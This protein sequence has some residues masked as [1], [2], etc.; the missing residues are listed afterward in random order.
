MPGQTPESALRSEMAAFWPV[1]YPKFGRVPTRIPNEQRAIRDVLAGA[2]NLSAD[3]KALKL[4]DKAGQ[5][6]LNSPLLGDT[7]IYLATEQNTGRRVLGKNLLDIFGA[8]PY[9]WDPNAVRVGVAALV[10]AGAVR[11]L[12]NKKPYTNPVDRELVDALRVSR[13]FNKVELVLEEIIPDDMILTETRTFLIH[14]AK[15][16]NIDETPAALSEAAGA[17][18]EAIL[19]KADIV[20]LWAAG[21]GMGLADAF[22]EGEDAWRKV[23]ALSNPVHRVR[24][25][26]AAQGTL[27]AGSNA[28][29]AHAR[30]QAQRGAQ[31]TELVRLKNRLEA[32]EYR[33]G[34]SDGI[35]SFLEEY[36]VAAQVASFADA[37]VWK[38]LQSHKAQAMLEL[39]PLLDGWRDEA[40]RQLEDTLDRLPEELVEKQ[41]DPALAEELA[42]PLVTLRDSL[43]TVT[44]PA[45]VAGLPGRA[46][47]TIRQLGVR[48][49]QETAKKEP[50]KSK[51][52]LRQVRRVRASDVTAV[53]RVRTVAE[54]ED[55]MTKLDQRVRALLD[56]GYDVELS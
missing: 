20:N 11:V 51:P 39:T 30:F 1:L 5:I 22:T 10:R 50:D 47:E 54:W 4:Y 21:S 49:V 8:P 15:R 55:L 35:R 19:A 43:E 33:L 2:S 17:L 28:I 14:L 42:A 18:A 56:E 44:L 40:R 48:I 53:T 52:E 41:L 46:A 9:G 23:V 25:V 13:D 36:R 34:D 12:I 3:V 37:E 6:D 7:R 38:R 27:E 29:E 16:R 32:I 26:H 31:F 45:Q 24:E